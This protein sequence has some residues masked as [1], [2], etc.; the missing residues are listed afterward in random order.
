M[1]AEDKK[2]EDD[3]IIEYCSKFK[4]K[5]VEVYGKYVILANHEAD[6]QGKKNSIDAGQ[7]L[8]F[9]LRDRILQII[10]SQ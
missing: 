5:V 6:L 4:T 10:N 9:Y 8:G 1:N 3:R 2:L 7:V